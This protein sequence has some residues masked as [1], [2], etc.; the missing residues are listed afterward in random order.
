MPE[1]ETLVRGGTVVDPSGGWSGA[2]DI[3]IVGGRIVDIGSELSPDGAG[4]VIDADGLIVTP[5]L[6]DLHTHVF[7]GGTYWGID[8]ATMAGRT[9]T[10]TW[11][12]AGSAGA[13][14]LDV[15]RRACAEQAWPRIRAFLNISSIGL[16]AE[17]GEL[18]RPDS[19]DPDLCVAT[20]EKNRDLVVGVKCRIAARTVGRRGIEPLI[21][22]LVVAD[23]VSLPLMVHIGDAPPPIDAVAELLRPGDIITHCATPHTMTLVDEHGRLRA[24]VEAAR[25]RGVILD[26]GHGYGGFCFRQA[27]AL[28]AEGAPPDVIS[29]DAHQWSVR[30]TMRDLPT[31]L[32]KYLALGLS[33][34]EVV[35]AATSRPATLAGLQDEVGSL[36]IGRPGDV[37]LFELR[38]GTYH[39]QDVDGCTRRSE[40]VLVNRLTLLDGK[41]L[42]AM[43]LAPPPAWIR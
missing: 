34:D 35:D 43:P 7:W 38:E 28:L 29:S 17:T 27:E 39:L 1:Y 23:A 10:T 25:R 9:G 14:T 33:L 24:S 13:F 15:F 3:G 31:C 36:T 26:V 32:S 21:Q 42:P 4:Q 8:P 41:P 11:V 2:A 30:G 18:T 6:V 5:G 16:V 37:A 20:I 40:H 22:A 19:C 12:D